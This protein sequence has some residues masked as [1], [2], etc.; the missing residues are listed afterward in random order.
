M[1]AEIHCVIIATRFSNAIRGTLKRRRDARVQT[2]QVTTKHF[3]RTSG[4][5]FFSHT[6]KPVCVRGRS[7]RRRWPLGIQLAQ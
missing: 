5:D 3:I 4:D 1:L 6:I 7:E 2:N